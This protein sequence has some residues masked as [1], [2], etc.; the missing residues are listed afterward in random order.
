MCNAKVDVAS[1]GAKSTTDKQMIATVLP[2]R[3]R[4]RG[5]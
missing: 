1:S 5:N 4:V 2:D 3:L